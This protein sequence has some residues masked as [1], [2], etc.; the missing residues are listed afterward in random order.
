MVGRREFDG[1][2]VAWRSWGIWGV[3]LWLVGVAAAPSLWSQ[4]PRR[5]P[6]PLTKE[7]QETLQKLQGQLQQAGAEYRQRKWKK[8]AEIL[9]QLQK[10]LEKAAKD[11]S[12][13]M[14]RALA[15]IHASI[16]R[17]HQLLKKKGIDD[18]P[19][20][21]PLV[22][23]REPPPPPAPDGPVL[24]SAHVAPILVTKC[25]R[26]HIDNARGMVSMV[27]YETLMKG[28]DAGAIIMPGNAEGSRLVEVIVEGDMPRGGLKVSPGELNIL[29]RWIAQG[30]KF[31]GK[32]PK[33]RLTDL[34]PSAKPAELAKV[35]PQRASGKETVRFSVD[36]APIFAEKCYG[37]HGGGDR[38]EGRFNLTS[39][40]RM[41]RGGESGP[42]ILPGRPKESLL[43]K[44][45]LGTGG[46]SRMPRNQPPLSDEIIAKIQTWIREGARLDDGGFDTDLRRLVAVA[47]AKRQTPEEV[48]RRRAELAEAN[49]KLSLPD[50]P[51]EVYESDKFLALGT[52][53]KSQLAEII[54]EAESYLRKISS[55]LGV[56]GTNSPVKGRITL[57]VLNRRYDYSEFGQMVQ[58]R[59][60]PSGERGTSSYDGVDAYVAV[61]VRSSGDGESHLGAILAEPLAELVVR[62]AGETPEW[63]RRG[64]ARAVTAKI[65]KSDA[66]VKQWNEQAPRVASSLQDA[67]QVLQQTLSAEDNDIA[68][69]VVGNVLLKDARRLKKLQRA[70]REGTPFDQAFAGVYG[71]SPEAWLNR[72]LGK[73][74]KKPKRR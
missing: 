63:Y 25:G 30:A 61:Y 54:S 23:S 16:G 33:E 38:P 35:E 65:L 68:A 13:L 51:H 40:R 24:F 2:K 19:E 20:L 6:Q 14:L 53:D 47:I 12:P 48:S 22:P 29:K 46:G 1:P 57:F 41:L 15:P 42:A 56:R 72:L 9:A 43:V 50:V 27:N 18:L 31:D 58:K 64:L 8:S 4:P 71:A 49:W 17:A 21:K 62:A 70:L 10:D 45:L 32:D 5:R 60:V 67:K 26:C 3:A 28:P 74:V 73:P 52:V 36:I 34:A 59:E 11:A 66:R 39:F 69:M 44:K 7:Q 37:C 55:A